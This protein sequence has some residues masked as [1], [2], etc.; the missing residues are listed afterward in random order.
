M[1]MVWVNGVIV[2]LWGILTLGFFFFS[3]LRLLIPVT[4]NSDLSPLILVMA[5]FGE[6]CLVHSL[7]VCRSKFS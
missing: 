5:V 1:A 3:L 7:I 6:F 2:T 4:L